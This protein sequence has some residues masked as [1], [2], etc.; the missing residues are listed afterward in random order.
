MKK[1]KFLSILI[2]SLLIF[3]VFC[4][5]GSSKNCSAC[6]DKPFTVTFD[7]NGGERVGGGEL[8]QTVTR[9]KDLVAPIVERKYYSF[10]GWD[11][12][13]KNIKEDTTVKA[14]W[15]SGY[16]FYFPTSYLDNDRKNSNGE[17]GYVVSI[18]YPNGRLVKYSV[19]G[20]A[21]GENGVKAPLIYLGDSDYKF[22]NWILKY[23]LDGQSKEYVLTPQTIINDA[24]FISLG[25][26][27]QEALELHGEE[28]ELGVELEL[29]SENRFPDIPR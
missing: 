20:E 8:V 25:F 17:K 23:E 18:S 24:F 21:F 6:K 13:L 5:C 26:S 28:F 2:A 22:K 12:V 16:K 19:D 4:G 14:I 10:D 11:V 15:Y 9:A 7:L 29:K 27:E 1:V 3:S